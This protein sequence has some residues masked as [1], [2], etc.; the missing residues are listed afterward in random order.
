MNIFIV[1]LFVCAV[2][3]LFL[4]ASYMIYLFIQIRGWEEYKK[5][6]KTMLQELGEHND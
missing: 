1:G 2:F 4:L 3:G 5:T 6:C